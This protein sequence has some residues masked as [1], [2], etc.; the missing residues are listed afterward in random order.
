MSIMHLSDRIG[1]G[2]PH[3]LQWAELTEEFKVMC[4]DRIKIKFGHILVR[5]FNVNQFKYTFAE[6]IPC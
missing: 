1:A 6:V 2:V 4:I 3:T 5:L